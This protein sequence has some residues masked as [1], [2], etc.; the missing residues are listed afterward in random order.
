MTW[1]SGGLSFHKPLDRAKMVRSI[2]TTPAD[3]GTGTP[4]PPPHEQTKRAMATAKRTFGLVLVLAVVGTVGAV[5]AMASQSSSSKTTTLEATT[6]LAESTASLGINYASYDSSNVAKH[7]AIIKQRFGAVRTFTTNMN[8]KNAI[9]EAA[10]AGLSIAAGLWIG[11]NFEADVTAAIEGAKRH[12]DIVQVIYCG[13]EDLLRNMSPTDLIQKINDVKSRVAAAG[14]KTPVGTVQMDGDLLLHPDVV[15]ACDKVGVNIHPFFGGSQVSAT[16]PIQDLDAR[17]KAIVDKYGDKVQLTET[18]W[19]TDGGAYTT[20]N[21]NL[22]MSEKYFTDFAKWAPTS[23]GNTAFYFMF[24]DNRGKS[25]YEAYFGLANP[26][27]SWKFGDNTPTTTPAATTSAPTTTSP[28]PTT[29]SPTTQ[30][31]ETPTTDVPSTTLSPTTDDPSTYPPSPSSEAPQPTSEAP[32]PTTDEPTPSSSS[33]DV[34][35]SAPSPTGEDDDDDD[36]DGDL[37]CDDD[38]DDGDN[39]GNGDNGDDNGGDDDLD[40]DDDDDGDNGGN[41]D[42]GDNGDNNDDKGEDNGSGDDDNGD[43]FDCDDDEDNGDTNGGDNGGDNNGGDDADSIPD[44]N[45]T[46]SSPGRRLMSARAAML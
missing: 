26:D 44:Q 7:F 8:G 24:H 13:S 46:G 42:N 6:A 39:G 28:D 9:D 15:G 32:H 36:G 33:P 20:H 38:D 25:G 3:G 10:N 21:A 40:C 34:T 1:R 43:D 17:W 18:G 30:S 11:N 22:A 31:P 12:P 37:D 29:S 2:F 45:Q 41:G 4:P 23:G 14:L 35:P 27:G 16:D 5:V 19:P